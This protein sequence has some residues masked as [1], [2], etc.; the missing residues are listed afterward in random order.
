MPNRPAMGSGPVAAAVAPSF[1]ATPAARRVQSGAD[2]STDWATLVGDL[3]RAAVP[4]TARAAR[5]AAIRSLVGDVLRIAFA[6]GF[7]GGGWCGQNR[8]SEE[9]PPQFVP[10][11]GAWRANLL[12]GQR[13]AGARAWAA[14]HRS[15]LTGR[16]Y[17]SLTVASGA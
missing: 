10:R 4:V 7:S 5:G 14:R 9:Y 1:C 11:A 17:A 12:V 13:G 2:A 15:R 8:P 16:A 6:G 3:L